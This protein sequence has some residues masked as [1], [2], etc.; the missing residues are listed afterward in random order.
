MNDRE[1][2]DVQVETLFHLDLDGRLVSANEKHALP[3]PRFFLGRMHRT[4]LWLSRYD[5]PEEI[6]R[7]LDHV[8]RS[9]PTAANF[10]GAQPSLY[11]EMRAIL[12]AHAPIQTEYFGASY[13]FPD[14]PAP[15]PG[16]V[17]LSSAQASALQG[18]LERFV[19]RLHADQPC[20]AVVE[21]DMA[22]SVA[23]TWRWTKRAAAVG[24]Y[25][26]EDY[27]GRGYATAVAATWS[28]LIHRT[29]RI[30]L[31]GHAWDNAASQAVTRRLGLHLIGD[32]IN[33]L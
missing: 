17:V 14:Q 27:R 1:L 32:E 21:G 29:G 2:M 8:G 16:V 3:A 12:Q 33:F 15:A 13:L 23:Y 5:L 26:L 25:T 9:E 6:A 10:S 22:L 30:A 31:Y 11:Q 20:V 7:N 18:P 24:V 4:N 28:Y 19:D